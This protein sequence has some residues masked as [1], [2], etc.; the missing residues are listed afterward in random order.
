MAVSD[1]DT[2]QA[3]ASNLLRSIQRMLSTLAGIVQTRVELASTELEEERVRLQEI[4]VSCRKSR[5]L[6]W[7]PRFLSASA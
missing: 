6:V 1:E 3:S 5:F 2:G 7:L 4:A